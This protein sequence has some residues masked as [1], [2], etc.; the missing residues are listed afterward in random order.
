[1]KQLNIM[2]IEEDDGN[3]EFD[4]ISKRWS[5]SLLQT[6]MHADI[7][8]RVMKDGKTE[9]VKNRFVDQDI[10]SI[11]EEISSAYIEGKL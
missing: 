11:V 9:I 8:V 1:M 10:Y 3:Y 5:R 7:A 6:L 4:T 2:L